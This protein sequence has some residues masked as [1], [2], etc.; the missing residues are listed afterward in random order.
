VRTLAFGPPAE[1]QDLRGVPL[2]VPHGRGD[3]RD[4]DAK[5]GR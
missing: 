4:R 3:L 5:A 2:E 1:L